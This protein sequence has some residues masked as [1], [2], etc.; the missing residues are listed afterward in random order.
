MN[1]IALAVGLLLLSSLLVPRANGQVVAPI[2]PPVITGVPPV[3]PIPINPGVTP[4]LTVPGGVCSQGGLAVDCPIQG[5]A[6]NP[7]EYSTLPGANSRSGYIGPLPEGGSSA[8]QLQNAPK[9]YGAFDT[10]LDNSDRY[11]YQNSPAFQAGI[12][13]KGGQT[14]AEY[15]FQRQQDFLKRAILEGRENEELSDKNAKHLT[16]LDDELTLRI[17]QD[18]SNGD[19][20]AIPS[21]DQPITAFEQAAGQPYIYTQLKGQNQAFQSLTASQQK[22]LACQTSLAEAQ[23]AFILNNNAVNNRTLRALG[24]MQRQQ[25][26]QKQMQV[27]GDA[28]NKQYIESTQRGIVDLFKGTLPVKTK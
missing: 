17:E 28:Q 22:A 9:A 24:E 14:E 8:P 4:T 10:Y 11:Q 3:A 16:A 2:E 20:A 12:A 18:C 26:E 15:T 1:K 6:A 23:R 7:G 21:Y 19:G 13:G 27:T 25:A 5:G